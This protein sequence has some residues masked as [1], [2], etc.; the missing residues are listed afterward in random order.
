MKIRLSRLLK[1]CVMLIFTGLSV[2]SFAQTSVSGK[3]TDSKDGSPVAGVTVSVKGTK[4]AVK[5]DAA[6]AYTIVAATNAPVLVFSSIGFT[7]QQVTAANGAANVKLAQ[8]NTQLQDVVVVAYGTKKKGDLTGAVTSVSA[9]DFQKGNIASS[10]QL[11]QGKVAGLSI[12]NGGGTPGGGSKLRIRGASSLNASNDPLIVIDGVPV[13]GNSINGGGNLLA[14]LNPNDIESMSVLKDAS[15]TALYGSRATNGVLI[16]TTK[17]GAKGKIKYNYNT[18]LSVGQVVKK[19]DVFTGD[20]IRGIVNAEATKTGNNAYKSLLGTA[21]T[22]WQNEIYQK[23]MGYDNNISASGAAFKNK[24]PFRASFGY[25]TQDGIIKTDN[26][27][28]ASFSLNLSPKFFD[29]HLSVNFNFKYGNTAYKHADGGA[30]GAAAAFDPTQSLNANNKY[31]GNF[32]WLTSGGAPIGNNGN[33]SNPNPLSLLNFRNNKEKIN[34]ILTNVQL[35]YKFTFLPD[36]HVLANIGYDGTNQNGNDNI[37]SVL[38]TNQTSGGRYSQYKQNKKNTIFEI[39]LAYNK[40]VKAIKTKI[41]LLVGHGYQAFQTDVFNFAKYSQSGKLIPGTTPDFL[42]DKQENRIESYFGR[43]NFNIDN[44][45]LLTATIRRDASSRFNP[46]NRVGYFP[47]FAAAWK[48]KDQFFSKTNIISDLKLRLGWGVTGQQDGIGNYAYLAN[49]SQGTSSA[50]YQF[51]NNFY[52]VYRPRAYYSNLKWETTT[53]Q[54]IGLDFGFLN[55]RISGSLEVYNKKTKDLLSIADQ[56]PGVNFDISLLKNIGNLE[57]KGVEFTLNTTPVK[58]A[59]FTWDFGFNVTFQSSKITKL[60]VINDPSFI[61]L[62]QE[63]ISG[64]TGNKIAIHQAGYSPYTF[65]QNRQVYD[66]AGKPIEGLYEDINRNGNGSNDDADKYYNSKSAVPTM[67]FGVNTQI[68]Y[69]KWTLGLAAHGSYNNYLYNNFASR[70]GALNAIQNGSVIS[71]G[72]R[73]YLNTKFVNQQYRSDYYIQNASFI[74]LD[75]INAGYNFG[76][77]YHDKANLRLSASVQNVF[78]VT[79]YTGLDPESSG[80]GKDDNIYPRPRVISIGASID[81]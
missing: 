37:D 60:D 47:S 11:L 38:V 80:N 73:D 50:Q 31:G 20:E 68:G 13:E 43:A 36:L 19:V 5:T 81:F 45:Y 29:E 1:I 53:T 51:G 41:D 42:T 54:N 75:N 15:A 17:K 52:Y 46:D 62:T 30:V 2:T 23:A 44:K 33:A 72:S 70:T 18:M 76:K 22:D 63:G 55:N 28:R 66:A 7:T 69:K 59:D 71:N 58:K 32:E 65:Y 56:A 79:K 24:L 9:K 64:G 77:I 78:V 8:S 74:R 57:N 61:G 27:K 49:Y 39:S 26:F 6:G 48:L 34:R 16:I 40:E 25:L 3:V 35:D 4:T 12:T 14:S 10:E 21:N 67:F